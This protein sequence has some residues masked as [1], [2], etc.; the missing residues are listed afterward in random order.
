MYGISGRE[1]TRYTVIHGAYI[2]F[3]PTLQMCPC[4]LVII[5]LLFT[6]IRVYTSQMK[7]SVGA[8]ARL[9]MCKSNFAPLLLDLQSLF[10]A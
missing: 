9:F 3:W 5:S 6:H 1:V 4:R 10:T 8:K 7:G 2:R